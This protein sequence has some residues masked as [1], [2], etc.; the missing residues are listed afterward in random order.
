MLAA[1]GFAHASVSV[2]ACQMDRGQLAHAA[3]ASEPCP[4]DEGQK[5]CSDQGLTNLC[6]SHCTA[7]LQ[8]SADA[9]PLVR[10]PADAPVV[11]IARRET[12]R[13][14][15]GVFQRPPAAVPIRILLRSLQI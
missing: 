9:I 8:I 7:D 15:S 11:L 1:A 14:L 5:G 4:C 3:Q 12:P 6:V 10:A 13:S 2:L